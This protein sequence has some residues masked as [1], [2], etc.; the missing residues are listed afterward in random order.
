MTCRLA[1]AAILFLAGAFLDASQ[2]SPYAQA[3]QKVV[4]S[5]DAIGKSLTT[6]V[7]EDSAR[8]AKPDLR[9]SAQAFI[10]AR[11]QAA[12][13]QPPEKDE[14]VRLEKQFKPKLEAAMKKMFTQ[15]RRVE[16][17]PGGKD[18]LKEIAGVL[19]KKDGK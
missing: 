15:V 3:L 10:D 1:S 19:K 14:K 8:A 12:K 11:T 6:I 13:M 9:K 4:D 17:I 18:A 7:D 2:A 16:L 5:F